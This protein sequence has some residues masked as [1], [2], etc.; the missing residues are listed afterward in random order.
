MLSKTIG[1][2]IENEKLFPEKREIRELFLP[3]NSE[4][5]AYKEIRGI[6]QN[7]QNSIKIID[8]YIDSSI[9][10][11]LNTILSNQLKVS[12]LTFKYPNDFLLE[13]KKFITQ[14]KQIALEIKKSKE[15][16]DRFI[17]KDNNECW[18]I[19]CSIKDAGDRAF[20]MSKI[21][22]GSNNS[23]LLQQLQK[24]LSLAQVVTI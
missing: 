22:D 20:M 4:H 13:A 2:K 14:Y 21:E 16:H 24:S 11:I 3:A 17:I 7:T 6:I 15:F 19:G 12:L 9:F 5:D 1:W 10:T 23:A 18:H 8:P